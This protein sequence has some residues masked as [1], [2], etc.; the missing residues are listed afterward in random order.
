MKSR[1]PFFR[2][3]AAAS[4]FVTAPM[5]PRMMP[6]TAEFT[7]PTKA[8]ASS[9]NPVILAMSARALPSTPLISPKMPSS[10][11]FFDALS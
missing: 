6:E 10:K 1:M 3:L 5:V 9:T 11:R 8:R 2:S 4:R 7:A